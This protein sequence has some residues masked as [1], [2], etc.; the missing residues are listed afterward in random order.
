MM[1]NDISRSSH[2]VTN[3]SPHGTSSREREIK[4]GG[5]K[6]RLEQDTLGHLMYSPTFPQTEPPIE[7]GRERREEGRK[8]RLEQDISRPSGVLTNFSPDRT[9]NRER[10]RK[11]GG[12]KEGKVRA[13]YL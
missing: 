9:S 1:E 6:E 8:E 12:R 2:V 11:K 13:R 3:V 10:E 4:K 5:R 7:R